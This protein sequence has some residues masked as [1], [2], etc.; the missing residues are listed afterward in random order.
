[1][2][3][4]RESC[5]SCVVSFLFVAPEQLFCRSLL[6]QTQIEVGKLHVNPSLLS[7]R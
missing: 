7:G 4:G 6:I 5:A 3:V 1:M 2:M